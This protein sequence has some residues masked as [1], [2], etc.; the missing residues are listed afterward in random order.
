[1]HDG[2]ILRRLLSIVVTFFV[3]SVIIFLM[4]H[5]VPGGPFDGGDMPLPPAVRE[6]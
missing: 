3:V 1:M 2:F 4:M 6:R 5:A